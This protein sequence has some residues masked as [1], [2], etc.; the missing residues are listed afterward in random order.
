MKP[1]VA[2]FICLLSVTLGAQQSAPPRHRRLPLRRPLQRRRWRPVLRRLLRARSGRGRAADQYPVGCVGHRSDGAGRGSAEVAHGHAGRSGDGSDSRG[3]SGPIDRGR[4]KTDDGR[5][6]HP[7]QSDDTER[8]VSTGFPDRGPGRAVAGS[9]SHDRLAELFFT[10]AREWQADA[11]AGND[12]RGHQTE[13]V[14]RSEGNDTEV[15]TKPEALSM[16][17][18]VR[19]RV[20]QHV[21]ADRIAVD[22][23]VLEV[24]WIV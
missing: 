22:R 24:A 23:E 11:G 20:E 18:S 4:R 1:H 19:H 15:A 3:V 2:L 6:A 5:R 21:D 17:A 8:A 16:T 12:G 14:D 7:R 13:D 10:A 9:G